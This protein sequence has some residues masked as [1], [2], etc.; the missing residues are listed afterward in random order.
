MLQSEISEK[1][2]ETVTLI[3]HSGSQGKQLIIG[4]GPSWCD[5]EKR[6]L[7][8]LTQSL[9]LRRPFSEMQPYAL[10]AAP[11]FGIFLAVLIAFLSFH[12]V[13]GLDV[14]LLKPDE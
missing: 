11:S 9:P 10:V 2:L 8:R 14:R 6:G 5:R 7:F 4:I 1:A 12:T 13:V 3:P